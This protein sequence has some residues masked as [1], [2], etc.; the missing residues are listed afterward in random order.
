MML[1]PVKN[2]L[3][4]AFHK[5]SRGGRHMV[6]THTSPEYPVQRGFEMVNTR[7]LFVRFNSYKLWEGNPDNVI[8]AQEKFFLNPRYQD[9]AMDRA[10]KWAYYNVRPNTAL[11]K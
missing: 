6:T 8:D 11:K 3:K 10:D 4:A 7:F 2:A 1:K 5:V 9:A